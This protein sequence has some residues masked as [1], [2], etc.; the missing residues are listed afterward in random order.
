M[1]ENEVIKEI[2][3]Y[4]KDEIEREQETI[5]EEPRN[6]HIGSMA[7]GAHDAYQRLLEFIDD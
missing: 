5:Q 2:K 3:Q 6:S 7:M 4:I 1:T